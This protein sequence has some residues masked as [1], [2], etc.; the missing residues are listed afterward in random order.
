MQQFE[1]DW[2]RNMLYVLEQ[3]AVDELNYAMRI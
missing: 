1:G 3:N 2:P